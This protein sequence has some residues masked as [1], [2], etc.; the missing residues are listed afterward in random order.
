M[1]EVTH[2][3]TWQEAQ[4]LLLQHTSFA[5]DADLLDMDK[6]DA[7]LVFENHIRQLE[8]DEEEEKERDKKRRKRQ[9]RKNRDGFIVSGGNNTTS[10]CSFLND[11]MRPFPD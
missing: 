10:L 3:T 2:K 1:T 4:S 8:K 9:E 11:E 7:L 5:E 6:E